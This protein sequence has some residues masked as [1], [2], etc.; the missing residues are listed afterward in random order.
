M[1]NL[2]HNRM[3]VTKDKSDI[4]KF[5]AKDFIEASVWQENNRE[6]D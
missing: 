3:K 4:V 2:T 5:I 1:V 6:S